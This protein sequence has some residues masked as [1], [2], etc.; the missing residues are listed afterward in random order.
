M[1][2]DTNYRIENLRL[3]LN[4]DC[5]AE[6][7]YPLIAY[8]EKLIAECQ[9]Q[10]VKTKNEFAE[11]SDEKLREMGLDEGTIRLLRK[12]LT[13]YEPNEQKF[14]EIEKIT[15][16]EAERKAFYELY[17]LPGVKQVRAT[18]YYRSGYRTL[19]ELAVSTEE[20]VLA[21]TKKTIE[22]Q[23]LSCIVPLPKEVRTHIVIANV[24]CE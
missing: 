18:L 1:K 2:I 12:F 6:R 5:L 9:S 17:H 8:K 14:K 3:L 23:N 19:K 16:D 11:C 10:N 4:E 13:I 15:T 21:R 20:E 7:Y 24:F 22:E